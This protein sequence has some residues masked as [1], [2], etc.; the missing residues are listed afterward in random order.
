MSLPNTRPSR[1]LF[2]SL[3]ALLFVS[4]PFARAAEP[5]GLPAFPGAEGF[6][7]LAT[8]GRGGS[9][10][11]VTTLSNAGPGSFRDAV[12]KPN[13]IVVFDV[14]GY[15]DLKSAVSVA[16]DLTIAGQSAPGE[17]IVLRNYEVSFSGSHNLIVRCVRFRHGATPGQDKKYAVG[18]GKCDNVIFDHCSVEWASW[19]SVGMSESKNITMQWCLIGENIDLQRFGCLCESDNVTFS[20]NL[21]ID[22]TSRNPKAKGIIEYVNNVVYNWGV[23]GLAG[24][25]SGAD[26]SLDVINNC[27]VK[28]PNSNDHFAAEY[29][30]SDHLYQS[31]NL[32]V[33]GRTGRFDAR[34]V[35]PDDFRGESGHGPPT[36]L[37]TRTTHP[38]VPVTVDTAEAA[39]QKVIAGAGDS[40]HRDSHDTRLVAQA[41]SLGQEGK[42]IHNPTEVGGFG[43]VVGGP[44]PADS[45]QDGIPDAWELAHHLDPKD[46]ADALKRD[47]TGYT[48]LEQYL[49]SLVVPEAGAAK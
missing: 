2:L 30:P 6:G 17:G 42:I 47:P 39:F 4:L 10:Y 37:P 24:G 40:L 38:A 46:P 28:G 44:A 33:L 9:V 36:F 19:D 32:A 23:T 1:A 18:A 12:S 48:N 35:T 49:N 7:A 29:W 14:G 41:R 13:R 11:H 34:P 3:G 43:E 31:G 45:D 22:N 27:F 25:H 26:H 5:A 20:H 21:W 8:G 15:V 16:S